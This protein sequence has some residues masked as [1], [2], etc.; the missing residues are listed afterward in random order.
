MCWLCDFKTTPIITPSGN[1]TPQAA[2][3]W[4]ARRGF[5]LAAG[6]AVAGG[7]SAQVDVGAASGM[8]KLV[9]AETLEN[10]ALQQYQQ[11]LAEAQAQNALAPNGHPQLV[12]LH[13]IAKR[14]IPYTQSWNPRAKEWRWQVNL[15]GSKQINAWCMPGGKIAFYTGILE[16]LKLNDD[17]VAMIMGHEMAH[18]LREHARER[19]SKNMATE[20]L[21]RLGGA[22]AAMAFGIDPRVT[23]MIARGGANLLTLK[24]SRD[25]ETEADLVGLEIAARAGY[26]PEASVALWRKMLGANGSGGAS[27]LSTHPSG[28]NRIHELEANL[29]K[30]QRLYEQ[31]RRSAG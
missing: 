7:A 18:A 9:P 6:A 28:A 24:F 14:L 19:L 29:P 2:H 13:T 4:Q 31:A 8:R 22:V 27:W 1:D 30:V 26:R 11:V 25:D 15:I 5:L 20:G 10:N 23:D 3:R 21:S 12:R 16:Q 17:E